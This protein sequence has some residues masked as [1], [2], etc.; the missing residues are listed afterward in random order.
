MKT[1]SSLLLTALSL[2]TACSFGDPAVPDPTPTPPVATAGSL[3]FTRD[4]QSYTHRASATVE[5]GS[6]ANNNR[7]VLHIRSV[8]FTAP[9]GTTAEYLDLQYFK[10]TGTG[11]VNYQ[12]LGIYSS[13]KATTYA[14]AAQATL[15]KAGTGWSGSFEGGFQETGSNQ[16]SSAIT[17]GSFSEIR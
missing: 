6:A 16:V 5:P 9:T 14:Y 8:D 11:D 10:P 1:F 15:T 7:D 2:L 3:T 12:L 4:G 17:N 13:A